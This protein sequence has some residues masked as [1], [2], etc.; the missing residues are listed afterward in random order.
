[1]NAKPI[2][3]FRFWRVSYDTLTPYNALLMRR[4]KFLETIA[5]VRRPSRSFGPASISHIKDCARDEKSYKKNCPRKINKH[6]RNMTVIVRFLFRVLFHDF[7]CFIK[8]LLWM[9]PALTCPLQNPEIKLKVGKLLQ[10]HTQGVEARRLF[11]SGGQFYVAALTCRQYAVQCRDKVSKTAL[12]DY[13]QYT[14]F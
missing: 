9:K 4:T 1:M 13:R 7:P 8:N 14:K 2:W 5:T 11:I 10:G 3:T 6:L 12:R